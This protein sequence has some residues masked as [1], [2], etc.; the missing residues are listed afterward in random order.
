MKTL[1]VREVVFQDGAFNLC[2]TLNSDTLTHLTEDLMELKDQDFDLLEWRADYLSFS[3]EGYSDISAGLD[4]IRGNLPDKPL[5]FTCRWIE[6]GG[7]GEFSPEELFEIRRMSVESE[8]IDLLDV[9]LH[10]LEY[11]GDETLRNGYEGLLRKAKG[12]GVK[13]ILSWHDFQR[14]PDDETLWR[15]LETQLNLGADICK[16]TTFA[17]SEQD[18]DRVMAVSESSAL[19]L[20]VPH[21]ALAMGEHGQASRYDR[22]RSGTCLTYAP[23]KN[24]SAPGQLSLDE[25]R[26]KLKQ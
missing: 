11:N 2:V 7:R 8:K 16:I 9:E 15:I 5:I 6:E 1:C 12:A 25:L 26:E 20:S 4:L 14:T 21:I 13:C 3:G 19:E 18:A 22:K 10:W 24:P 17:Q 23:L